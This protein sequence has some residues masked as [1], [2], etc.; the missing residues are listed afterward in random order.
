I[1]WIIYGSIVGIAPS[2]LFIVFRLTFP[3][4]GLRPIW[5]EG[6]LRYLSFIVGNFMSVAVPLTVGYAVLKYRAFDV[7]FVI[8]R[9]LQYLFA[10]Q[11]LRLI[12][13]LPVAGLVWTII[14]SDLPLTATLRRN[15]LLL[16]L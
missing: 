8:R 16:L 13:A 5:D 6:A 11:I 9:G 15:P 1:K 14:A 4:S 2:A 10:K 3:Y 12:L 7:Q